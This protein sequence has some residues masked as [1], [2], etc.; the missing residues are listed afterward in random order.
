MS[1][2]H[3]TSQG[4]LVI[5]LTAVVAISIVTAVWVARSS[6]DRTGVQPQQASQPADLPPIPDF[7]LESLEPAVKEQFQLALER[8]NESPLDEQANGRL[9]M[10]FH[11]YEFYTLAEQCYRRAVGVGSTDAQWRYY[12][13]LVLLERGEW[14]T[15]ADEF[16]VFLA[17]EPD[18]IPALLHRADAYRLANR[19]EEALDGYRLV[20][21]QTTEIAQVYCGAGQVLY[22]L[23]EFE[24]AVEYLKAAVRLAPAYGK[25][26]YVLGQAFRNSDRPDEAKRELQLAEEYRVQE[27]LLD[28][29]LVQT[30]DR[31]RIGAIEAL[32]RGIDMLQV[33]EVAGA[34]E[35]F[36][37][38]IQI[39]P[40]L[41]EAHAQLGAA[42]LQQGD[43]EA[44]A[45]S[46]HRALA[47][48]PNY[49]DA[50]YHLG[51][52][53]HRRQDYVGAVGYFQRTVQLRAEHFD[54]HLGLGTDLPRVEQAELAID[55]LRRANRL[56]PRDPRPYRRL[57]SA[58][59]Q[60]GWYEEAIA[61]LRLGLQ[62]LPEDSAIADRLAWMLGTCPRD[63]L[64]QADEALSL[65]IEVCLRT[66]NQVPQALDTHAA[67]LA[68]LGRFQEAIVVAEK[69]RQ[70][71]LAR[72]D[73]QLADQIR[74]RL[75]LYRAAQPYRQS[76]ER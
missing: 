12:L 76:A 1:S 32:H 73:Q 62:T 74:Q 63:E 19:L 27:P 26:R 3:G 39:E 30:L 29:P 50:I 21:A 53:A 18:D 8:V 34:T 5:G 57:A 65:A 40:T 44:A 58:L 35:L 7:P 37:T 25:A 56:R 41:A 68:N 71:A 69:A 28:D 51:L 15:A 36:T 70:T 16:S 45:A 6:S 14:G 46:L 10:L 17:A 67:A 49:V 72:S 13:G 33:G 66:K 2:R 23:G 43:P 48:E 54:A 42:L 61:A 55:H 60:L 4:R 22:R 9:G 52:I 47:I 75:E 64:R 59:S 11:A 24:Q 31:A 38:A 20:I